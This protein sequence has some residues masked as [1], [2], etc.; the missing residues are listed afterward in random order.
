MVTNTVRNAPELLRSSCSQGT[1]G[2]RGV[3]PGSSRQQSTSAGSQP[4]SASVAGT[5]AVQTLRAQLVQ[6][7]GTA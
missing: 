6:H 7:L 4:L 2:D 1:H 5:V 3:C